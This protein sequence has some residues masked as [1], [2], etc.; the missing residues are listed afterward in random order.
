MQSEQ[1][2]NGFNFKMEPEMK[3]S[4]KQETVPDYFHDIFWPELIN[5]NPVGP[6]EALTW[7]MKLKRDDKVK[8]HN[9]DIL[10]IQ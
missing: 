4:F 3:F 10:N 5:N 9:I 2:S 8:T 1:N 7:F 6:D